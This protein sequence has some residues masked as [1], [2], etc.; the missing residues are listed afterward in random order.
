[1]AVKPITNPYPKNQGREAVGPFNRA[2]DVSARY[3]N[4]GNNRQS[5]PTKDFTNNNIA[6]LIF[7]LIV[8]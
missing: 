5:V 6:N 7:I 2:T 1:M 8:H 3:N 4:S